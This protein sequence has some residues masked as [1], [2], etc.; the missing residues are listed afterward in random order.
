MATWA[1]AL[2][3][4]IFLPRH[5]GPGLFGAFQ[6]ANAFTTTLFVI[7][8]LGIDTYV[9]KEVSTRREHATEL[10][11]GTLV[12][13]LVLS[14]VIMIFAVLAL[15]AAG[16]PG[17]VL[18]LVV[19][20]GG[21]QM[22]LVANSTYG[23]MLQAVGAV[24]GLS[25]LN[26]LAKI[27]W[28]A[29]I[30]L[31]LTLGGGVQGVALAM[32]V[33]EAA[34][35][36]GLV[37]LTRRHLGLRF[38]VDLGASMTVIRASMPIYVGHLA[39]SIYGNLDVSIMSFLTSDVEVGWY[40][41]ASTIAGIAFLLSP[42]I[43]WVLMPL[44]SRAKA[45]SPD[46]VMLITRRAMEA[47]LAVAFPA[48]LFLW[49]SAYLIVNVAFG[50]AY[51]PAAQS[52][53]I[54]APSFVLT[55][56]AMVSANILIRLDR[57]WAVT[58]VSA[59]G[60]ALSGALNLWLVPHGLAR[61]GPGGAGIGA[62]SALIITECWTTGAL[63]WLMG[64]EAFDGRLIA[65]LAKTVAVCAVVLGLDHLLLPMGAWRLAVDAAVYVGL[66][67]SSGAMDVRGALGY[68]LAG[69]VRGGRVA[70]VTP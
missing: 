10:F 59:I 11:G 63:V 68:L 46:E 12:L 24:D 30:V 17:S 4:R 27:G 43:L 23:A 2:V 26:V 36:C 6:F 25:V 69:V 40:S 60:I 70:E 39:Q 3:V 28:G 7:T 57:A 50:R 58:A 18:L 48:T 41:A 61:F 34:R 22:L 29:G 8:S 53:R 42:I 38:V 52:L 21:A 55:Y 16:K 5:L 65:M 14:A 19:V 67:V 66:A 9:R 15:S 32:L 13:R 31:A 33:S 45:R 56:A 54:L 64:R 20:L 49:I 1:V 62:A 44:A 51:A 37:A 47:V 35:T